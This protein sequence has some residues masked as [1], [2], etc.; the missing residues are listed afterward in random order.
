MAPTIEDAKTIAYSRRQSV[1]VI[2][3]FDGGHFAMSSYGIT[4]K[5][6]DAGRGMVEQIAGLIE[7]GVIEVPDYLGDTLDPESRGASAPAAN[8]DLLAALRR[9]VRVNDMDCTPCKA[10]IAAARAAI[11]K[12]EGQL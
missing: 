5:A 11:A 7:S 8:A 1:V 12:A 6:C 9:L 4:R 3:S 2:L 10:D